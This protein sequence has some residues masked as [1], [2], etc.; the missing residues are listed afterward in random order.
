MT[1]TS[2]LTPFHLSR[3]DNFNIT[4]P[5]FRTEIGRNDRHTGVSSANLGGSD[6]RE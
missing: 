1:S 5:K 6:P 4:E 2:L 3:K